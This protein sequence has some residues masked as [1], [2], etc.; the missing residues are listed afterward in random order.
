M[1]LDVERHGSAYSLTV[2]VH[3]ADGEQTI[4][5]DQ[6]Q[7]AD[8]TTGLRSLGL[9]RFAEKKNFAVMFRF[10]GLKGTAHDDGVLSAPAK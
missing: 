3:H 6:T 10:V 1:Y 7:P 8:E 2:T 5:V 4:T 9:F